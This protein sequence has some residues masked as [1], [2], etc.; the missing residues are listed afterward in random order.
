M[1]I[2]DFILRRE[3]RYMVMDNNH[4]WYSRGKKYKVQFKEDDRS[5][6]ERGFIL[7]DIKDNVRFYEK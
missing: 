2:I 4:N 1:S 5:F 6:E 3:G 7:T